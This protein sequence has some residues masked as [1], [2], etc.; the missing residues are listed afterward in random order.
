M[1]VHSADITCHFITLLV[2][3]SQHGLLPQLH[4][5][6]VCFIH[7]IRFSVHGCLL[8]GVAYITVLLHNHLPLMVFFLTSMSPCNISLYN[9]N[10]TTGYEIL[11]LSSTFKSTVSKKIESFTRWHLAKNTNLPKCWGHDTVA[12]GL[13]TSQYEQLQQICEAFK[14]IKERTE[15]DKKFSHGRKSKEFNLK[16]CAG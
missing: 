1:Q 8:W 16:V 5:Q 2:R 9:V 10:Y 7:F 4:P 14:D 11:E 3:S 12:I 15:A 6:P 13:I